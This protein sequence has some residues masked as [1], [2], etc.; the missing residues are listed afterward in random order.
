MA[1]I[2]L[3]RGVIIC[4]DEIHGDLVYQGHPHIPIASL[5]PEIAHRTITLMAPSKTYNIAGL[6][7][8]MAI[9]PNGELRKRY[10]AA[11]RGIVPH[12]GLI[13]YTAC[14][15]A[16]Q[17]GDGWLAEVMAYLQDNRDYLCR[18]MAAAFPDLELVP[19]E[20]TYLAWIDCRKAGIPGS[21]AAFFIEK[22]RVAL[23]DGTTFGKGGEGFVRLNFGCPRATLIQ[24][25]ERMKEALETLP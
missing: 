5:A 7:C 15:A 24:A 21:P 10:E 1:R 2:C 4:S 6:D 12:V 8:A 23:N 11:F 17:H 20:G 3:E 18:T 25:V 22:A 16:Y 9:I 13:G 19:P 14:L